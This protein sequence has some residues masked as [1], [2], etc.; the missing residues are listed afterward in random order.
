M[1]AIS[2][3]VTNSD[4]KEVGKMD[5]DPQVFAAKVQEHLVFETTI[6]QRAKR[7]AGT[8]SALTKAEVSGG[9]KK[10][11]KQKG[12]GNARAGSNTSPL[13]VGGGVTH[14]PKP[15]DYTTRLPKRTRLTALLSVLT[16]KRAEEKIKIVEEFKLKEGKTR[17]FKTILDKLG[18]AGEKV[19]VLSASELK[20][21]NNIP[22]VKVLSPQAVNVYDLL[23][24]KYFLSTKN[25]LAELQERLLKQL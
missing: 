17:E 9:G 5:L 16:A 7:R 23:K 10:P 24:Y 20:A 12:T 3:K 2:Y 15:R 13:W 25:D 6:W 8:H 21:A 14:G 4:G 19:A 18:L 11:Y 1:E 22:G